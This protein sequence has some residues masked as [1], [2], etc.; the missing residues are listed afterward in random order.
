MKTPIVSAVL[1]ALI[2]SLSSTVYAQNDSSTVAAARAIGTEGLRLAESGNCAEAIDR[3][4]RAEKLYHAPTTQ[5]RL[6]MCYIETGQLVLG[7]EHLRKVVRE[8][9]APDAPTAF[10]NAKARA[11]KVLEENQGRVA[12]LNI[13]VATTSDVTPE[14]KVDG[15]VMPPALLGA[16]R[17]TDPGSHTVEATAPGHLPASQDV[18]LTEGERK[19]LTFSLDPDLSLR[20]AEAAAQPSPASDTPEP[21]AQPLQA[22]PP[23]HPQKQGSNLMRVAGWTLITVGGVGLVTGTVAGILGLST[24]SDLDDACGSDKVCP[25]SEK[26]KLDQLKTQST[27]GTVG[28][29]VGAAGLVSGAAL[30]FLAPSSKKE[31]N[32]STAPRDGKSVAIQPGLGSVTLRGTF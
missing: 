29:V 31:T 30:L 20:A 9:L 11:Q 10:I 4:E 6:G 13:E 5:T 15:V 19:S 8:P 21:T 25:S 16:D 2:L 7:L 24:K 14:V 1:A 27:I 26:D 18:S 32:T 28:F 3:L 23:A 17:P 12:Q 22:V